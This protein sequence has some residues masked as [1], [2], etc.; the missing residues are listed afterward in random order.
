MEEQQLQEF[1]HR[2]A[3][4]KEIQRELVRDPVG[5]LARESLTPRVAGIVLRLVP[6]L[7]F[8]CPL[9]SAEK[10]WHV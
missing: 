3:L 2:V 7:T 8:D 10:W 5:V 1:V 6:H 4:D 9:A